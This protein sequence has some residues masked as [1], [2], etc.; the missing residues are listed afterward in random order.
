MLADPATAETS[1]RAVVERLAVALQAAL[2]RRHADAAAAEAFSRSRLEGFG[3]HSLGMLD[4]AF[5]AGALARCAR[6]AS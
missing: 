5:D 1:A 3:G 4:A 6:L 2:M